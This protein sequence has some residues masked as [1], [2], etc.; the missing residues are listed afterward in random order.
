MKEFI[1]KIITN[2]ERNNIIINV[3]FTYFTSVYI[4]LT[5]L[6]FHFNALYITTTFSTNKILYFIQP[7]PYTHK[8]DECMMTPST[9]MKSTTLT[10]QFQDVT[11]VL[12]HLMCN[13]AVH[14]THISCAFHSY[15]QIAIE[16][17]AWWLI[18]TNNDLLL[19]FPVCEQQ[20]FPYR[21][22]KNALHNGQFQVCT[23]LPCAY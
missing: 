19:N 18:T 7:R 16:K 21:I 17:N 3:V 14:L 22:R 10:T 23:G 13:F 1:T 12:N 6:L 11:C 4:P 20:P 5:L 2:Y 9:I 15:I 8:I